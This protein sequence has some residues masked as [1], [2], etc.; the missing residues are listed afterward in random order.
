MPRDRIALAARKALHQ[1]IFTY[2]K[3]LMG[4]LAA[5]YLLSGIYKIEN[6]AVGVVTRF[7]TLLHPSV[8][9]GLHYKLPWPVDEVRRVA[10]KQVKTLRLS[11]FYLEKG[12]R[13]NGSRGNHFFFETDIDPY[14]IT[15]D[16][17]IVAVNLLIKYTIADPV[18]YLF[19]NKQ[20][21]RLM[22]RTAAAVVV[23]NLARRKIDDILTSGKKQIEREMLS[24][25]RYRMKALKTGISITFLEIEQIRPPHTVEDAFN[26]VINAK[27]NKRQMLN[28]AQGYYN[29]RVPKARS[30]ADQIVQNAM[31]HKHERVSGAQGQTARFLSR[32][33]GYQ[34]D[35]VTVRKNIFL[36]FVRSIYPNLKE[37]RVVAPNGSSRSFPMHRP[38]FSS[39]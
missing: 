34:Q 11:D 2:L 39:D 32:L 26:Q 19:E 3:G 21:D 9:P 5:A 30:S 6:D 28:E 33:E 15:G 22:E 16:N 10:V 23:H 29:R 38:L 4:V 35:P 37:I 20:S 27:V 1:L 13:I 14:C 25:M 8:P 12:D 31:A 24:A 36:S 17:N 18:Q 7:G